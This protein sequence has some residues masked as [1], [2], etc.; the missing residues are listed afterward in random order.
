MKNQEN[1][2]TSEVDEAGYEDWEFDYTNNIV[3]EFLEDDIL[4]RVE[5][6]DFENEDENYVP[7]VA[8]FTLYTRMIEILIDNG[9]T[10]EELK[11]AVD[12]FGQVLTSTIH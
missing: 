9:W 5:K 11:N 4:P 10:Q 6:F 7:G 2:I 1:D 8:C 12:E 3:E